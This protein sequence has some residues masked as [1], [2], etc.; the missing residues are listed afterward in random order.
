M[1]IF[2]K[3]MFWLIVAAFISGIISSATD[4]PGER[5]AKLRPYKHSVLDDW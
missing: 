5:D 4:S 3:I 2:F 1:G